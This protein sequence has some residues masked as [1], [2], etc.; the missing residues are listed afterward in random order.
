MGQGVGNGDLPAVARCLLAG[1]QGARM[2]GA[3]KALVTLVHIPFAQRVWAA[4][5]SGGEGL[6]SYNREPERLR[7]LLSPAPDLILKDAVP[8]LGPLGGI[9]TALRA[10]RSGGVLFAPC[11]LPFYSPQVGEACRA[12]FTGREGAV[13]LTLAGR[14]EPLCGIYA[15][16]CIPVMEEFLRAGGRRVRDVLAR[17]EVVY[18]PAEEFGLGAEC[19]TNVNTPAELERLEKQT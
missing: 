4:L 17:L 16:G 11:D 9:Y 18:L 12:N 7:G 8:G 15:K 6:V 3:D 1:G 5:G 19:F 14:P 13:V 2:G 10:C